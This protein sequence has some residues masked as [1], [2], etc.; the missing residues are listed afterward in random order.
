MVAMYNEA[1]GELCYLAKHEHI[2]TEKLL[3]MTYFQSQVLEFFPLDE[4]LRR[5]ALHYQ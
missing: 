1:T 2:Q 5:Y 4:P 3:Q